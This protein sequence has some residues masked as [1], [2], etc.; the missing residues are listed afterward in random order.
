[1]S[2]ATPIQGVI[3]QPKVTVA[4]E[5]SVK[6]RDY[7]TA[8]ASIYLPVEIPLHPEG[9]W[10]I[11]GLDTAIQEAFFT[12]KA[13]VFSQLGLATK[14]EDGILVELVQQAIP[15]A[16]VVNS[17]PAPAAPAQAGGLVVREIG[18]GKVELA[19]PCVKCGKN[20]WWDNRQRKAAG[21]YSAKAPDFKCADK[22][23]GQGKWA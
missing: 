4:F 23:C 11:R 6:V 13:H 3:E 9:G 20:E 14:V 16:V 21:Q 17:A 1:M 18:K 7:E 5:R 10:D 8:K 2:E 15:G 22:A 12:A 19:S